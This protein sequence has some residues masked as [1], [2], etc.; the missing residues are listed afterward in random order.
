MKI[1]AYA[2]VKQN[3]GKFICNSN[4][5]IKGKSIEVNNKKIR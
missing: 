1:S 2:T 5:I 4:F 3:E